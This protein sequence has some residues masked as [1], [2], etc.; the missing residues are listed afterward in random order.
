MNKSPEFIGRNN[1]GSNEYSTPEY[2]FRYLDKIFKFTVD[3][4]ASDFSRKCDHFY[5][6]ECDG[7]SKDW[8]GDRA[9]MNP[10][11][12]RNMW[13]WVKKAS[14]VRKGLFQFL[15][16]MYKKKGIVVG[17]IPARTCTIG[18]HKYVL[19]H[20]DAKITYLR[21]RIAFDHPEKGMT[22]EAPWSP[23][24]IVFNAGKRILPVSLS[25]KEMKVTT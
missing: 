17:L 1:E 11:Y 9:W 4:C 25:I 24:I 15:R 21:G 6:V 16:P 8:D 19:N 22:R 18:F 10:P 14:E 12:G 3:V 13:E 23:L 5:C 2:L 20:P 7:L